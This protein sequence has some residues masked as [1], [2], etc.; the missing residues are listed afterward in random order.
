MRVIDPVCGMDIESERAAARAEW[1]GTVY[2]FCAK[3]CKAA[4]ERD[5]NL[6]AEVEPRLPSSR[7]EGRRP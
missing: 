4:F 5:P 3:A 1:K 7:K 2:H 6:F